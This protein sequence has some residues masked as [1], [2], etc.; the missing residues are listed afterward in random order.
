MVQVSVHAALFLEEHPR[1]AGRGPSLSDVLLL[2]METFQSVLTAD[3]AGLF[4][5]QRRLLP[6]ARIVRWALRLRPAWKSLLNLSLG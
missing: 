3:F 4:E 1:S 6:K 2:W 5:G